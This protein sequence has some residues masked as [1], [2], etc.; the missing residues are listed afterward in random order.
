MVTANASVK[1]SIDVGEIID[2]CTYESRRRDIDI[3]GARG[4]FDGFGVATVRVNGWG[5]LLLHLRENKDGSAI[6]EVSGVTTDEKTVTL[7]VLD[8]EAG[9]LVP[10]R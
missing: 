1:V 8:L 5:I 9:G 4:V 7:G 2:S 10:P 3:D 6:L